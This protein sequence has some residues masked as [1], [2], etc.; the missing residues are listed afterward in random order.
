[1]IKNIE[2]FKNDKSQLSNEISS[3]KH[4]ITENQRERE[5]S[6][7]F[8][9]VGSRMGSQSVLSQANSVAGS[10]GNFVGSKLVYKK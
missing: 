5:N 1:M 9:N 8:S 7:R 3:L 4:K 2:K 6:S 10:G